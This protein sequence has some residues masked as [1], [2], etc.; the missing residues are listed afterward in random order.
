MK[1]GF[2]LAEIMIVL[3][4]IGILSAV[5][6]PVAFQA[7]PDKKVMKFK[8]AHSVMGTVIRELVSSDQYYQ[9]G[10][11][12]K[13]VGGGTP[14]ATYLCQTMADVVT[15]KSQSCASHCKATAVVDSG[16]LSTLKSNV[17][18]YC[19][20]AQTSSIVTSDDITW[21]ES[22]SSTTFASSSARGTSGG[23]ITKYKVL[24]FD[25]DSLNADEDPFGYA[26]R[27]D[28]K[29]I[30]GNRADAWTQRSIQRGD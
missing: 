16:T 28:G 14:S 11:L 13:K 15:V 17:D 27:Y 1:K 20:T 21:F 18:S 5:L 12:G 6:M 2:T 3:T 30:P 8:K 19:K 24:C 4:V 25:V 26:V 23:F 22:C 10:D 9:D 7:A 29:I